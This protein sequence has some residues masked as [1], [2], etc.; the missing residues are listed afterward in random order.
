[1]RCSHFFFG[2]QSHGHGVVYQSVSSSA[3]LGASALTRA[4][5]VGRAKSSV[6]KARFASVCSWH[7]RNGSSLCVRERRRFRRVSHGA[8]LHRRVRSLIANRAE[9]VSALPHVQRRV[10]RRAGFSKHVYHVRASTLTACTGSAP[11]DHIF[12]ALCVP[13]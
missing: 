11:A 9:K 6:H 2:A 3:Q 13:M 7:W 8:R 4:P 1:M 5:Q 12:G 10:A